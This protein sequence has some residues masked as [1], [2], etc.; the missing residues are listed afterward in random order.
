MKSEEIQEKAANTR[1]EKY[2]VRKLSDIPGNQEK[3]QK[4]SLQNYGHSHPMQ[5]PEVRE[6]AKNTLLKN[7]G[8]ECVFH[9][10]KLF[11]KQQKEVKLANSLFLHKIQLLRKTAQHSYKLVSLVKA[12]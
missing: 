11:Q 10:P 6:R 1:L 8:V 7:H 4:T 9:S 5:A 2:G 12:D 3:A